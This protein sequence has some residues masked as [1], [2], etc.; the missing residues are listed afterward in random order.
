MLSR[1]AILWVVITTVSAVV[2]PATIEDRFQDHIE[3]AV[4]RGLDPLDFHHLYLAFEW[5][6]TL[7]DVTVAARGLDR[8]AGVRE[9]DPLM[10]DEV[11]LLRA[12]LAVDGGRPGAARELFRAMGGLS[13]WWL[14]GPDTI[15]ELEDISDRD[16]PPTDADWR[17]V[18]GTDPLGWV[19]VSGLAWPARRQLAYLATTIA[20]D[21]VQAVALRL[22]AAQVARV[23]LNGAELLTTPQPLRRA[24]DQQ[25]VGGWLR[26]GGNLLVVAVASESDDWWLRVRLTAPDGSP[27]E[28]VR[29]LD[30]EPRQRP[31]LGRRVPEVRT[32]EDEL[33]RATARGKDSAAI[34]LAAFLVARQP[35]PMAAGDA[36]SACRAARIEAPGEARLLEWQ[37]TSEP[38]AA[39]Q[40]LVDAVAAERDLHWARIELAR[41]YDQRGLHRDAERVLAVARG[42]PAVE[43]TALDLDA[44]VWGPVVLARIEAVS[45]GAPPSGRPSHTA[46]PGRGGR[47]R[48]RT[49]SRRG[50]W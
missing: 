44:T 34:A 23:W 6:H 35:Q 20:S 17:A 32:I 7:P 48:T 14:H 22:G 31:A 1:V 27:L 12:R 10:V 24:E 45:L 21:R 49:P 28:G 25:V 33:R 26:E 47:G 43:A 2:W 46:G 4:A 36:R 13:R 16:P 3:H 11:R 9:S 8:L 18:A 39:R 41:W 42:E 50:L 19:R 30:E 29:E 15:E 5:R 38:S 37:L 40:L